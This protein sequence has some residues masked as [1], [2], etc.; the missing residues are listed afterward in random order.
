MRLW[1]ARLRRLREDR[2]WSQGQVA[3][4]A[5]TTTT[6][7]SRLEAD[8]RPNASGAIVAEI[9]RALGTSSDY[10]YGLTDD[11]RPLPMAQEYPIPPDVA[12]IAYRIQHHDHTIRERLIAQINAL[13]D[14]CDA[15]GEE[16]TRV[17]I[18]GEE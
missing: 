3:Y 6:Q 15:I 18:V 10:L 2:E 4:K 1:G 9:A 11:P 17:K 12:E 5:K 16:M 7:I 13:L 8:Q 14:T